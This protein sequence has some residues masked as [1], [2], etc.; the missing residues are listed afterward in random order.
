MA[1]DTRVEKN[2]MAKW[3]AET[4]LRP[5]GEAVPARG[6]LRPPYPPNDG[7]QWIQDHVKGRRRYSPPRVGSYVET[8]EISEK[9]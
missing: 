1:G 2:E 7:G 3:A 9:K 4:P 6:K 5:S 8:Y